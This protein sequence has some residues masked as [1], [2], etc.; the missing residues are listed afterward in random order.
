MNVHALPWH[1]GFDALASAG[2]GYSRGKYV[3]DSTTLDW[4]E[5]HRPQ[6]FRPWHHYRVGYINPLAHHL[7]M[8]QCSGR[9][10]R[11]EPHKQ[12]QVAS[13]LMGDISCLLYKYDA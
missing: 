5:L 8:R 2:Y 1:F 12:N 3:H 11:Y 13:L 10:H 7:P 9:P 4:V 6:E